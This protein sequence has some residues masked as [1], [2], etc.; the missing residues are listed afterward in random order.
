MKRI[1]ASACLVLAVLLM[2]GCQQLT[3]AQKAD[4]GNIQS[5]QKTANAA[6]KQADLD[7]L[8]A[9]VAQIETFLKDPKSKFGA[10]G[11][12][13]DTS[14]KVAPG[15]KGAGTP[16]ATPPAKPPEKGTGKT[17]GAGKTK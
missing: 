12:P 5:I 2:V 11:L 13:P 17:K 7:A 9:T 4:I 8:K 15:A 6:A 10:Y 3:D 16:P 1:V 14:K